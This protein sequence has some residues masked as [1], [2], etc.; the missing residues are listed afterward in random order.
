MGILRTLMKLPIRM[1]VASWAG[2]ILLAW[3]L[4][5]GGWFIAEMELSRISDRVVIDVR[6]LGEAQQLESEILANAREYLS[7]EW[8]A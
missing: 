3:A 1:L 7:L 6:S 8:Q 2:T 4:L 5:A